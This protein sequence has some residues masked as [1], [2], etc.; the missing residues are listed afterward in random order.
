MQD[1][2]EMHTCSISVGG[3][4]ISNL[5]F[6][7]DIDLIAGSRDEL[8]ELTNSLATNSSK[9]GM[10][11]STEKSKILINS[12]N[13]DTATITLNG[14]E[15]EQ[16][17]QFKY[18][19]ST[20]TTDGSSTVEIR[21]RI[22]A[23]TAAMTRLQTVWKSSISF[24]TKFHL[25]KTLVLSILL[26]GCESW[27]L[28]A[29]AERRIRT[30]ETKSFRKL[31]RISY[32]DHRTNEFVQGEIERLAGPYEPLLTTIRRRK[33]QWYGH[34]TR[35]NTLSKT[36]MQGVMEGTRRRGRPKKSWDNNITQWT[37]RT[38][39]QLTRIA[40]DRTAWTRIARSSAA[41]S[42]QRRESRDE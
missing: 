13:T 5:R 37:K 30:F 42:P 34:V 28:L 29:D 1:T 12:N 6:A 26:Y 25:Y 19:G 35:H 8:Q 18:L 38:M 39:P 22:S 14:E 41:M 10:E 9:F 15:L 3:R 24:K 21:K 17:K 11:V 4:R 36:I 33:L 7:D 27:T 2:L 16:V 23:A 20:L 31:L 32:R 40:Q